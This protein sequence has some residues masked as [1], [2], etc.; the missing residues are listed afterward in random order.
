MCIR[1][2][3]CEAAAQLLTLPLL[4]PMSSEEVQPEGDH[5]DKEEGEAK[6]D[7]EGLLLE[8]DVIVCGTGL[9]QSIVA[10]ALARA[11]KSVLH[12]DGASQ[13]GELDAV[14]SLPY[15]KEELPVQIINNEE[16]EE[17]PGDIEDEEPSKLLP[18]AARGAS[19]SYTHLTLPTIYSV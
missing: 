14:W 9:V 19:V 15:L 13:Y 5:N 18:L 10:S 11:G 8:Y 3:C 12:C 1:D 16:N 17:V 7:E 6:R 4:V 2:S